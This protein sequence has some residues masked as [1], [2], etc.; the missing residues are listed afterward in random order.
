MLS[1]RSVRRCPVGKALSFLLADTLIKLSEQT[2]RSEGFWA[3]SGQPPPHLSVPV[4]P[5]MCPSQNITA[6]RAWSSPGISDEDSE[7]DRDAAARG[8]ARVLGGARG[9]AWT[10]AYCAHP[11]MGPSHRFSEMC[12]TFSGGWNWC[13]RGARWGSCPSPIHFSGS[14]DPVSE[15][16]MCRD[17]S[18]WAPFY[19][20][21][22]LVFCVL[23]RFLPS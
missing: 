11:R 16:A 8:H 21:L 18:Y 14:G 9:R 5:T 23:Y 12:S 7:A 17:S 15:E 13:L 22:S 3:A 20:F 1:T 10:C 2:S 19:F 4:R 6:G